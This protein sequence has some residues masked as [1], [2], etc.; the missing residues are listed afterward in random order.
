MA[1]LRQ[2][3]RLFCQFARCA[4]WK[5]FLGVRDYQGASGFVMPELSMRT[6]AARFNPALALEAC[7]YTMAVSLD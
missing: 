2:P 5:I 4:D 1:S 6:F 7:K 3:S